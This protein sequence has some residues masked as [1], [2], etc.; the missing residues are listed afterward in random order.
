MPHILSERK[1]TMHGA[2]VVEDIKDSPPLFEPVSIGGYL[3]SQLVAKAVLELEKN[4]I[5]AY[6]HSGT[7]T[8]S[9]VYYIPQEDYTLIYH[10]SK[11]AITSFNDLNAEL[12]GRE[13][14]RWDLQTDAK[15]NI[16]KVGDWFDPD[17]L[18]IENISSFHDIEEN[19]KIIKVQGEDLELARLR[20]VSALDLMKG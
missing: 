8:Q 14:Q 16:I 7:S 3:R 4:Q 17:S 9:A 2:L 11:Y 12:V 5:Y 13:W 18:H 6:V 19:C 1:T 20:V 10:G 15:V